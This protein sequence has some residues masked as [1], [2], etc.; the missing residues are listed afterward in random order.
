M[1]RGE[2]PR[3]FPS[4]FWWGFLRCRLRLGGGEE[5]LADEAEAEADEKA[6]LDEVGVVLPTEGGEADEDSEGH[7]LGEEC[8]APARACASG[9]DLSAD[10]REEARD[11]LAICDVGVAKAGGEEGFL[12]EDEAELKDDQEQEREQRAGGGHD[13]SDGGDHEGGAE[14][15]GIP[16][17]AVGAVCG[18]AGCLELAVVNRAGAE[19]GGAPDAEPGTE[20]GDGDCQPGDEDDAGGLGDVECAELKAEPEPGGGAGA[21]GEGLNPGGPEAERNRCHDDPNAKPKL[22]RCCLHGTSACL[23]LGRQLQG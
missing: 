1:K 23:R 22:E 9:P 6:A 12:C 8:L 21:E 5:C 4:S 13:D 7:E 19:C 15:E 17:V 2:E 14:V 20:G 16:H 18:D 11:C 3:L 10:G